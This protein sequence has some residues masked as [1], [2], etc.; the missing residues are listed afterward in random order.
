MKPLPAQ[1]S[2]HDPADDEET[3]SSPTTIAVSP[4]RYSAANRRTTTCGIPRIYPWLLFVST[5][6]AGIFCLMYITKP[7]IAAS[8]TTAPFPTVG[9]VTQDSPL[10]EAT[11]AASN[12]ILPSGDR[13]PGE[14]NQGSAAS[15][16]LPAAPRQVMPQ[17]T[18]ANAFEETNLRI[19]HILTA[20]APGG[21]IARIDIEV[22][23]L[24]QSRNLRWTP[25]EVAEARNLL[26]RLS[27]YQ[28]RSSML[29]AEGIQLL[30]A[31]NHLVERSIPTGDLR[32][33]SPTLPINQQDSFDAPRPAGLNTI[34]SI[35]I[36]P[37]GK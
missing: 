32:A 35:Q 17:S 27:D 9:S 22:P 29:R 33:D 4:G 15:R 16:P 31:W 11:P 14:K 19:Q 6:I 30:D 20:E 13:L 37:A 7:V 3:Q 26:I 25:A 2:S 28:E 5:A 10:A 12:P 18:A 21:A 24:Y 8:G 1:A 23:V 34:D 36:Q